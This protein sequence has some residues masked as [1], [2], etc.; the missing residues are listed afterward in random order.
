MFICPHPDLGGLG[1]R[2]RI[3]EWGKKIGNFWWLGKGGWGAVAKRGVGSREEGP[4]SPVQTAAWAVHPSLSQP[5]PEL[6]LSPTSNTQHTQ[7]PL[8]IGLAPSPLL[9]G[10]F[11]PHSP[12]PEFSF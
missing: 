4:E 5:G 9:Y 11:T 3:S 7:F 1:D 8:R 2:G 12:G 10:R 6:V